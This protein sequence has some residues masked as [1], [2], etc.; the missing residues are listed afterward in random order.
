MR[1]L[2]LYFKINSRIINK[3]NTP[4]M[5]GVSDFD[6]LRYISSN[7]LLVEVSDFDPNVFPLHRW[8]NVLS[9]ITM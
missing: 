8:S 6:L 5:V 7:G 4:A 2:G 9:A 1:I 3:H